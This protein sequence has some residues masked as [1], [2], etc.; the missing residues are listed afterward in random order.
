MQD[1]VISHVSKRSSKCAYIV[2]ATLAIAAAAAAQPAIPAPAEYRDLYALLDRQISSFESQLSARWDGSMPPVDFGGEIVTVNV[3]R[4]LQL[5][6]IVV[7]SP[8]RD[9]SVGRKA[10][11]VNTLQLRAAS[12]GLFSANA[13]GRGPAAAYFQRVRGGTA[14]ITSN[15][16]SI[17]VR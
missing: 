7:R 9:S 6:T 13:S 4:G 2:I 17:N 10:R 3:N 8:S 14:S 11:S 12:P 16:V 15:T 5:T 1:V